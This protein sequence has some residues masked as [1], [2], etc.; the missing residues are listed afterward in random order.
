MKQ[1]KKI[2]GLLL[3][4]GIAGVMLF[5]SKSNAQISKTKQHA[6]YRGLIKKYDSYMRKLYVK[7]DTDSVYAMYTY[8]AFVDIDKNGI[9]SL[10]KISNITNRY[11]GK[12][13][14]CDVNN[15]IKDT[16]VNSD[17]YDYCFKSKTKRSSVGVLN[18]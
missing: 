8:Y 2:I 7:Q 5:T 15:N 18:V 13:V 16:I 3:F 1:C 4:L 9:D 12:T 11:N 6:M 14:I 10:I 17:L